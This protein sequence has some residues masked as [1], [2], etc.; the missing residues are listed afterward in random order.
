LH[1]YCGTDF[2]VKDLRLKLEGIEQG[3]QNLCLLVK[4]SIYFLGIGFFVELS[5]KNLKGGGKCFRTHGKTR[6]L[7][8]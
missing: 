8:S 5:E 1:F 7:L 6:V 4:I 2:T 3:V